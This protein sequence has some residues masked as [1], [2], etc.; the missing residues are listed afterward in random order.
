M[1][2]SC[3]TAMARDWYDL[4]VIDHGAGR[5]RPMSPEREEGRRGF[6]RRLR[7]NM[8]KT[9][10]ALA[11]EVQATLFEGDLDEE[12]WER[13]EEALIYADVGAP[14]TAQ[15]VAQLEQEAEERRPRRRRG[16]EQPPGR[17]ARA[18]SRA[19]A[20]TRSTC[21]ATPTVILVV[22]VNGTGKTTTIGKLAWHLQQR[23]R[24]EGRRSAPP[25][26]S[27]PPPSSSSS[28]G[29]SAPAS[30]SS[31][32]PEDS[33]PGAV[34]FDAVARGRES[35]ADV[36]IFDTAGRLHTQD[37]PDGRAQEGPPRDRQADAGRAAR[38]AA[39]RRRHHR[40]ERP[41]PGASSSAR[42]SAS[43]GSSSPSS[44]ARPRAASRSRSRDEL[45]IPVKLIG[46]GE[47]ARGPAAV[48]RRRL[49][50]SAAQHVTQRIR[51]DPDGPWVFWLIAAV[52]SAWARSRRWA[53]SSRP[54]PSAALVAAVLGLARC[55]A[56]AQWPDRPWSSRS[57]CC[58][59]LRP[60]ARSHRAAA[61]QHRTGT[62][63]AGRERDRG[64]RARSPTTEG[65]GCVKLD[66][67]HWTARA[68][69]DDEVYEPGERV[70][71]LEIRGATALV[72]E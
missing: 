36:V 1:P 6:F 37:E 14:T 41:A 19:P 18:A 15:V 71:V 70:Q 40:P 59:A 45:R 27:A 11:A 33:D 49:R 48:R 24:P 16:A 8:R 60:V 63:R 22:G 52:S 58:A 12:T 69:D 51:S 32:A 56:D 57:C 38:D 4:F 47:S 68:F 31:R 44:T 13:L 10:E 50:E 46:I 23:A 53:S 2:L 66:G 42:R 20:T 54:S 17:A 65:V 5:A 25:T 62:A 61:A 64:A 30:T 9:R 21:A 55:R 29:A 26:P 67:E 72:T 39:D 34:A 43:P 3:P 35:G 7:E 28:A